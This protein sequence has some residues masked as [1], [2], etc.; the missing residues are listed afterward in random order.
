MMG[1]AKGGDEIGENGN[2][3]SSLVIHPI[4]SLGLG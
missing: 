4:T 1:I 2:L 3:N